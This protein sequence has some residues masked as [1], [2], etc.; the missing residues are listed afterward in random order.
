M[1]ALYSVVPRRTSTSPTWEGCCG[2]AESSNCDQGSNEVEAHR[3]LFG[4]IIMRSFCSQKRRKNM[5]TLATNLA[6]SLV[7]SRLGRGFFLHR[8]FKGLSLHEHTLL[9]YVA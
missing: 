9:E 6:T 2:L 4:L 7:P 1:R 5:V 8:A 3:F